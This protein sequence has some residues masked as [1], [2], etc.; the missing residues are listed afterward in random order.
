MNKQFYPFRLDIDTKKERC[1]DQIQ[2]K[3][4]IEMIND[5][6]KLAFLYHAPSIV[7]IGS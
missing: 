6:L 1:D 5:T 7:L 4:K 3:T 2:F